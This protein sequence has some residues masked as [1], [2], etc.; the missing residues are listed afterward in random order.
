MMTNLIQFPFYKQNSI[1]CKKHVVQ[2]HCNY[3]GFRNNSYTVSFIYHCSFTKKSAIHIVDYTSIQ[4][5]QPC[6]PSL[7]SDNY[8]M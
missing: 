6:S 5:K 4:D 3:I 7:T 2:T 8:R 1:V